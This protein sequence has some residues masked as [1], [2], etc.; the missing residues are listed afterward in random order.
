MAFERGRSLGEMMRKRQPVAYLVSI[1]ILIGGLHAWSQA[2]TGSISGHISDP[3]GNAVPGAQVSVRD[4]DTGI[5]T[6][7]TTNEVGE[8]TES[9]LPPNH[10]SLAVE[11]TGFE[12]SS[13][14]AFTLDIDQR[15]RFNIALKVGAVNTNVVVTDSAPI[16]QLQGAETG[17]VIGTKEI[18]ELPLEG[19]NFTGLMLLIPGVGNGGGGNNLNL[20]VDG[21]REFSN[22]VEINGVE[23]TGNRNNDTNVI[24]SPDALQE[25]KMVTSTYAPEFGRASGGSVLIQTKS[26]SNN[27]HGSSYFFYRP[28]ATAANN[29][30]SVAGTTPALQQKIY[31]AT[32]GGPIK[33]GKAFFFLAY[34]GNREQTAYSY[35]G[36]T[37]PV[38]QVAFDSAG[39]ADLSGLTDPYTGNQVPIFDP[40]FFNSNYYSEQFPDNVIPE[41]RVSPGG[42]QILLNLFPTPENNSFFTNFPVEQSYTDDNNVANLRTD[43]TFSQDNRVY[44]TYDAEQ[45]DTVTGDPYAGHIPIRGGGSADSG[46]LTGFE[47]N[48]I[49]VK[50]EHVF[51][52]T[53][54]NELGG[55][56]FLST[57]S[58]NS[59]LA[60]TQL[61]KTWGIQNVIIP[62]FSST[63]NIPQIQFQSGPTVGG[64]TYKPLTFRDKNLAFAEA[65]TWTRG[66]HNAKF[67][68]EYRHLNSH[69]NFSLF[70]VPYEYIGG[71]GDAQTSDPTYSFYDPSAYYYN[72]GSEI[73]DLLLG[74]PY[75]V[76]QGLQ[77]T[78]ASTVA[79]EHTFYGQDY[80]QITPKLN[81]TYGVRYEY[82]QPY[83][84]ANN[85]EANF[86]TSKLLIDL[87]GRGS[88]S[89]SL[90][91][92]NKADFMPR[93]GVAYQLRSGMVLRGGFGMF[94]SPEND[95]REDILTKNYPYFTQQQ[96]TN[97]FDY[98]CYCF[99]LPYDLD[100]GVARS[101]TINIPTGASTIDLTTVPGGNTQ[102]IYSEPKNFPTAYSKNYNVTLEKQLGGATSFELGYV[103]ATTRNLSD[104][105]GNYN[106]NAH[107]SSN[108]GKVQTLLPTG[109]SNYDSLQAK[110]NRNFARGYSLLASYTWAHGRDNGPAPFDLGKGGNYPQNPFNLGAEYANSDT[111]MR[112]HFVASQMI[113]LPFGRGKHFLSNARG[114]SDAIVG[115]WQLNSITTLQTG[116]PFNVVSNGNDP[117]YP[118]LRP[119]L[120]GSTAVAHKSITEWF[121]TKAFSIPS[122]QAG[123]TAAGK[124]LIVGDAG[125]NILYGPGYTNEDISLFKVLTLPREMKF[126]IRIEAFNVLNTAHYD[127]PISDMSAGKRFG[128]ITGGYGSRV[129]QFA[130]RL[131]F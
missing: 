108:L 72:G 23:V 122:G 61:A 105:V 130:G 60:G 28:T 40:L 118:G 117:N 78:N 26:G 48:V 89:K 101:T 66:R 74:L 65:L 87:A 113:E 94:Y 125:R 127:N 84:E 58:Q 91:N 17:Q 37:P 111:D 73:A 96:F 5:V 90:V 16:I 4:V 99:D 109:I 102:T 115:G 44:L 95:A 57:V 67:G 8:F 80:W 70:P 59:P 100:T 71:A 77:L 93:V 51:S 62:G 79:N 82:Q 85:E 119:D 106:V 120:V 69:P 14:P 103:G 15:A 56:Y 12:T 39:N 7:A 126:Q 20:S 2:T 19:R 124:T 55:S 63:N 31:G 81:L 13:V 1:V 43:Y 76:D 36:S 38:N 86:D 46:D 64:S 53:L 34:E 75:V 24:P 68:Y 32:I 33:R 129:M 41:S 104:A 6:K 107:L 112:N 50:Y 29:S 22:S 92:S 11:A 88:N 97:Y 114:L 30:F 9:A 10:Y 47:N 45:G 18:T 27:Y 83:V 3:A 49:S 52:P 128:E 35:L 110:V 131:T 116:K 21:Q 42:K 123:S 54:L 25:F 98:G 121:N